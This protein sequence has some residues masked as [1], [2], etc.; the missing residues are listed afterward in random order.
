MSNVCGLKIE[1]YMFFDANIN[2]Y[3]YEEVGSSLEICL[4]NF[5]RGAKKII[6]EIDEIENLE[7]EI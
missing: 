7:C 3:L 2:E 6:L 5:L 4:Y 1:L